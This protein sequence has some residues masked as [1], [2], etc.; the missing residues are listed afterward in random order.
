MLVI[1]VI[2]ITMAACKKGPVTTQT[3]SAIAGLFAQT[4]VQSQSFT[5]AAGT[6][7]TVIGTKGTVIRYYPNSFLH[8]NGTAVTGNVNIELKEIY[9]AGDMILSNA[10]T[11]SNGQRLQSG[12]EVYLHATQNGEALRI[13][14]NNPLAL[15]FPTTSPVSGMQLFRGQF[16]HVDSVAQDSVLNW[17][18]TAV[19]A[20]VIQ[21]TASGSAG[22]FY[23]FQLDSFGWSNCD[24]FYSLSGGTSVL[25]QS[26]GVYTNHNTAVFLIFNSEHTAATADRYDSATHM[27]GFHSD[28][29]TPLGLSVTIVALSEINGQYYS[30]IVPTTTTTNMI[31]PLTFQPTTLAAFTTAVDAL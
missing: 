25:I 16:V 12:G 18:T 14:H 6:Y 8:Q 7:G 9:S 5:V 19:Q 27:F 22:T 4:R 23:Y 28:G 21:D 24:R 31:V 17:D 2:A 3:T 29:H 11:T 20:Q 15:E 10:T 13:D 26:S 1:T 30:S